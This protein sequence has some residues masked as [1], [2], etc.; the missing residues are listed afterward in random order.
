MAGA[1]VWFRLSSDSGVGMSVEAVA[2]LAAAGGLAVV[3]AAGTDAWVSVRQVVARLLGRGDTAQE[4]C[5]L[6]RLDCM[7]GELTAQGGDAESRVRW[8]GVWQT[9]LE[10]VLQALDVQ[11][12]AEAAAQLAEVVERVRLL[13]GG[14]QAAP[15]GVAAGG[16]VRISAEGGSVAGAVVRVEGGV[17]LGGPFPPGARP[18]S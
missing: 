18:Q 2:A 6:Q 5:E 10:L 3:Q 15:G 8:E 4:A 11:E 1:R 16:D 12:R 9:R 14:V 7:Q 17:H 13:P